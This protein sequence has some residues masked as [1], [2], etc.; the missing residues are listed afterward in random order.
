MDQE[1]Q[2][3]GTVLKGPLSQT[4]SPGQ[5]LGGGDRGYACLGLDVFL[6]RRRI[7][8]VFTAYGSEGR[9]MS[10]DVQMSMR[11]TVVV[12]AAQSCRYAGAGL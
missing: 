12:R 4:S 1:V 11:L 8:D 9:W 5:K 7:G 10:L 6:W 2:N 3:T